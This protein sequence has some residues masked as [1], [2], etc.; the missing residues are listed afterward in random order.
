MTAG[1]SSSRPGGG[2]A[3]GASGLPLVEG[4]A[5]LHDSPSLREAPSLAY[6][7]LSLPGS[8]LYAGAS[9][10][11]ALRQ[12]GDTLLAPLPC[13]SRAAGCPGPVHLAA[14]GR[15]CD[16][17]DEVV[18]SQSMHA[19]LRPTAHV[20]LPDAAQSMC[21]RCGVPLQGA[22]QGVMS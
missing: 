3:G 1:F 12:T 16:D 14:S 6:S 17:G 5:A 7:R 15:V 10:F 20:L 8:I 22:Q 18:A 13:P 2:G 9:S 11:E 21:E 19:R 4:S